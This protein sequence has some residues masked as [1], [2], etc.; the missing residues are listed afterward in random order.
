MKPPRLS[1]YLIPCVLLFGFIRMASAQWISQSF[2]LKPGW[3][4]VFL[5]VDLSHTNL[6]GL[7]AA[8]SANP[9]QELW[10]WNPPAGAQ[11]TD[12]PAQPNTSV[13]WSSWNRTNASSA[14]QRLIGD[15]AYLVR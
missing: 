9:I 12:D 14:L 6:N 8:D 1:F 4:A 7:V 15:S 13:E 11:F 5:H 3:N 10:R 2:V